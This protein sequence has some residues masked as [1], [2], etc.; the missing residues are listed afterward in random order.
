LAVREGPENANAP[1]FEPG[2]DTSVS[3]PR[4]VHWYT[5]GS[6]GGR[7]S[8][9]STARHYGVD[10]ST[11][12]EQARRGRWLE[13][14]AAHDRQLLAK[15]LGQGLAVQRRSVVRQVQLSERID[16]LLATA[17]D[18]LELMLESGDDGEVLDAVNK[19]LDLIKTAQRSQ[20]LMRTAVG[21][22]TSTSRVDVN[23]SGF[24]ADAA[25]QPD[26]DRLPSSISTECLGVLSAADCLNRVARGARLGDLHAVD[27]EA[28]LG[29]L[30][31]LVP[32]HEVD[33]LVESAADRQHRI[34]VMFGI[35]H[36]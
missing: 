3:Y 5:S 27:R 26:Y 13:R 10:E 31:A 23:V 7:R 24:G 21:L 18:R 30:A 33:G 29:V 25:D 14:A 4:L 2:S 28:V 22:P 35:R 9:L 1:A 20:A 36:G 6:E 19:A 16:T 12:R 11:L 32:A 15:E 8:F 17:M 34:G